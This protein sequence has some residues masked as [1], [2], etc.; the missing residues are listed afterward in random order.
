MQHADLDQIGRDL[1]D[2]ADDRLD[3]A[4]DVALD[5]HRIFLRLG[6]A[7]RVKH[8][9]E[10]GRR[11]D[12]ALGGDQPGAVG[13]D[14]LGPCL[15]VHHAERIAGARHPRQAEDFD[16]HRR[17]CGL[18]LDCLVVEQ[19]AHLAPLGPNDE[20]VANLECATVD[21]HR[22]QRAAA[23]VKPR[24]DDDALGGAVGVGAQF[25]KLGLKLN[26]LQQVVEPGLL[27]RRNLDVLDLAAESFDLDIVLEQRGTDALGISPGLVHLVD[28]DD[29]RHA[30][31]LGVSDRLD[32]LRHD[33][34]VPRHDEDDDVGDV[35]AALAHVGER[36]MAW[37]IEE[38]D[39]RRIGQRNLICAN[40]L[41]DAAGLAFDDIGTTQRVEQAG[42]AVI[43]VAHD[44]D[45]GRARSEIG[46]LVDC[47]DDPDLDV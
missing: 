1:V 8:R 39:L 20:D 42:L 40:V 45:D 17:Q 31:C 33:P 5:D 18:D 16:R 11:A 26:L 14:L 27:G 47:A 44:R 25:E 32:R 6:L 29:H 3:A 46:V 34:V 43:D 22:R 13:G 35:G 12:G 24:L 23:L 9:R 21:Q 36:L 37:C 28:R 19:R 4:L 41:G 2:R 10:I 7:Q 30:R 15:G 38:G